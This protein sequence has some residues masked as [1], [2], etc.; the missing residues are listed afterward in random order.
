[1]KDTDSIF[2]EDTETDGGSEGVNPGGKGGRTP[3]ED[4]LD[5]HPRL[6]I[7]MAYLPVGPTEEST[8]Y[9][10]LLSYRVEWHAAILG[11]SAGLAAGTTGDLQL[12]LGLVSIALGIGRVNQQASAKVKSEL[13]KEPWYA[14]GAAGIGYVVAQYAP[15]LL[16][17]L[18]V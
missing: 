7:L 3:F 12:V 15:E 10:G 18:G 2:Y 17:I 14:V 13:V 1:M 11:L 4:A 8:E 16:T 6:R 5:N 9:D